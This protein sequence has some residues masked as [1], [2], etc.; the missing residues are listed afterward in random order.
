MSHTGVRA[1]AGHEI[2]AYLCGLLSLQ[3][4]QQALSGEL[5]PGKKIKIRFFVFPDTSNKTITYHILVLGHSI[6]TRMRDYLHSGHDTHLCPDFKLSRT[7]SVE[8]C[9]R[10]VLT[11][12]QLMANGGALLNSIMD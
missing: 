5:L 1:S 10:G 2:Q 9:G 6:C 7:T 3:A 8:I 12:T 11:V 4:L